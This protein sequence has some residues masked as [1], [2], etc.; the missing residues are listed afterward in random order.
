MRTSLSKI[1]S[2]L[3]KPF[4]EFM[5]RETAGGIILLI[6]S[7]VSLILANANVGIAQH[8]PAIWENHFSVAVNHF[9]LTKSLSH[10]I[11]DGLMALFFLIVGLEIKREVLEGELSTLKKA[12]LPMVSALG[13]MIVPALVYFII[14]LN[15][16]TSMGWGIPMA[17]DIAFAL[18]V[19]LLL[20]DKVPLP[21][22]V[23]LT[24]LAI[25]DDLGAVVVIAI[26]YTSQIDFTYLLYAG[27]VWGVLLLLN[28][29]GV[30]ML[31]VYLVIGVVLWYFTLKSGIHATIAGVLLA[32]SIPFRIRYTHTQLVQMIDERLGMIKD[33]LSSSDMHPRIISEELEELNDK[34]SS[35][36]Q[37][38]EHQMHHTVAFL[39][40]PLFAFCNTSLVIET[41]V[42]QQLLSP[43]GL[44]IIAGLVLGK[45]LGISFFAWVAV[46]LRWASLPEGVSWKQLI[47]VGILGGIGF[48]MSIFIT[49][50]AFENH[51]EFQ[52]VAKV[53]ILLASLTSGLLGYFLLQRK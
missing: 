24:A 43:L 30:K 34:I 51:P 32:I 23:F 49:L 46:R 16:P 27:L 25:V 10:W 39:I 26:F 50:L 29:L 53:A 28:K 12:V 20:G 14:N 11:N 22:K 7:I 3:I 17:T 18:A 33:N 1:V 21:L 19:L 42:F 38:L 31:S 35:P 41:T 9:Q 47:G 6:V 52:S 4:A 15:S 48:T 2:P 8:F 37:K 13:G 36:A 44:G 45:P 40:I 5:K